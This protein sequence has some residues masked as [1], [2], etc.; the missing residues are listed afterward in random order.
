MS[1]ILHI[2]ASARSERS[3]T[4]ELTRAFLDEYLS[5]QP[6]SD[7]TRRD[8]GIEPPPAINEA[9]IGAAFAGDSRTEDQRALL[10]LSD[11]L[12]DEVVAADLILIGAP[13]Y[14]Y[15]M[16]A[17]LKAW[18]DQVIRVD[19]TFTFDLARG[20]SP[21]EPVLTGKQVVVM[22]SWGE[23]GFGPGEVNAEHGHLLPHIRSCSRYLGAASFDHLAVEY[24]EFGDAR[25]EASKCA[26]FEALPALVARLQSAVDVTCANVA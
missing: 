23:F 15:G 11:R 7:I 2:D 24:Q 21:L 26:A 14:N 1:H 10:A 4:R 16:P 22:A 9:W 12:I 8:V 3:I 20:D 25:H 18:F 19:R 13:M 6:E 5:R 17:A